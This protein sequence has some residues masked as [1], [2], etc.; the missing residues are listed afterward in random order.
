VNQKEQATQAALL[1]M[2]EHHEK[3]VAP[4][5]EEFLRRDP[6]MPPMTAFVM[7]QDYA[8]MEGAEARL[9]AGEDWLT[10]AEVWVG[11]YARMEWIKRLIQRGHVQREAL[12][13]RLV[14]LWRHSDPDDTDPFWLGMWQ[15]ARKWNGGIRLTDDTAATLD[16]S[17]SVYRGQAAGAE[18]GISWSLDRAA[19]LKFAR[20]GGGRATRR[21]GIVLLGM[22]QA[23][24]VYAYITLRN[25][26]EIVSDMVDIRGSIGG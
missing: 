4:L 3:V 21:D 1:G 22:V 24:D 7:G 6:G 20:T 15:D 19:A 10:I 16:P 14:D 25:E 9:A 2:R 18:V 12:F 5:I 8:S 13:P 26:Q 23:A 11:S 17:L